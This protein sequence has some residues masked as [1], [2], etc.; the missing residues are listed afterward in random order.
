MLAAEHAR[1]A[2]KLRL[3]LTIDY[4]TVAFA[5]A[6]AFAFVVALDVIMQQPMEVSEPPA[7]H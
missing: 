2:A 5:F 1:N 7:P 3:E 4:F 6:F